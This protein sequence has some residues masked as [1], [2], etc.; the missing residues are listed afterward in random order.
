VLFV[1][2]V[3]GLFGA[4]SGRVFWLGFAIFG[5][6][7]L[8]VAYGEAEIELIL[9]LGLPDRPALAT[10][11]LLYFV[12]LAIWPSGPDPFAGGADD[13]MT[14]G[15]SLFMLVFGFVGGLLSSYFRCTREKER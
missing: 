1:A 11:K 8:L 2:I 12:Y 7:Y 13:F 6:G 14:I 4:D 15:H 5:W 3:R 9:R 10:T